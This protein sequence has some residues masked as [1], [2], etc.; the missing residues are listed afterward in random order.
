MELYIT[1]RQR[2]SPVITTLLLGLILSIF[3]QFSLA[4]GGDVPLIDLTT[5]WVGYTALIIFV[6][7]YILVIGEEQ[8]HMRKSKPVMVAAGII[9]AMIAVIYAQQVDTAYHHTAETMIRHN[10]LE[11]AEL[12]LFLLAAMTFINTMGER[13][14]FDALRSWLVNQGFSL[15]TIFW[16]TGILSFLISPIADNLTTALLMATVAMAV[17]G[18]N[19]KFV[20][21]ACINI[22]V[23]A[24]AGGAFSPFGDITT[25]MVWQKGLVDFTQFFAL[26]IPSIIN[27]IIPA[28]IMSMAVGTGQPE[29]TKETVILKPGAFV[30]VFLLLITITMAVSAHSFLH[31]PPVIGMMTGLGFL[32]L[33][34]YYLKMRHKFQTEILGDDGQT[35]MSIEGINQDQDKDFNIF[36]QLER[37]EWDTL[38]FFYGIIL[39]V[40]G[41]GTIGYLTV[42]SQLMYGDLGA[43]NANILVGILS[44]LIDNIPVMFAVLSMMPSMDMGQWLLVTLTA[45]V[46]GSML[47]IGSAA[48]VAVMGQ[49]RGIY[50]F[51]AHL[52]WI[53]AIAL[54]YAASIAAHLW[55]NADLFD[56][57]PIVL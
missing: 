21:I 26:C 33:Y 18:D 44:A 37:A 1:T 5:H 14:I 28:C 19:I 45:G 49:A 34:G 20:S 31:I 23:A 46:G 47:S 27:W 12:F 17:G 7:A 32:K 40:G 30:V 22:V 52:K 56:N 24:N 29:V 4:A 9:W 11:Y 53:W 2:I 13:G 8:I 42:G 35:T 54:G 51:F 41:L 6:F 38:M 36:R 57:I 3:P 16:I 39:T 10:L 48:G 43:T 25:L 15:R 55:L 50:T